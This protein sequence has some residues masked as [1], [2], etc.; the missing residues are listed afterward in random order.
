MIERD[1]SAGN[2]KPTTQTPGTMSIADRLKES[3]ARLALINQM[4]VAM[5]VRAGKYDKPSDPVM[6]TVVDR[7][8]LVIGIKNI[9]AQSDKDYLGDL[10]LNEAA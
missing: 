4:V 7:V 10:G 3:S 1:M 9:E 5:Q 6:D 2:P 8:L